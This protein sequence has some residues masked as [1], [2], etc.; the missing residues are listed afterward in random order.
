MVMPDGFAAGAVAK[1]LRNNN[2]EPYD[3]DG[4]C[5]HCR[6]GQYKA[7]LVD[8]AYIVGVQRAVKEAHAR[9][10]VAGIPK[11]EGHACDDP[12][13]NTLLGHRVATLVGQLTVARVERDKANEPRLSDDSV[14]LLRKLREAIDHGDAS[15]F[16]PSNYNQFSQTI[17]AAIHAAEGRP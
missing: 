3:K 12:N 10:D 7:H 17:E 16:E 4:Y 9:L 8:C 2:P 6:I 13:C 15:I 14:A 5:V 11:A 1:G